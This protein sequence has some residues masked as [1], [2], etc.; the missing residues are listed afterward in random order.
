MGNDVVFT[1]S[2]SAWA[3][4]QRRGMCFTPDRLAQTLLAH[5]RVEH[6]LVCDPFRSIPVR[7]LKRILGRTTG[8][9]PASERAHHYSPGSLR[10]RDPAQIRAAERRY[11]G[12]GRRL[13][14]AAERAGL[15]EPAVITSHP[16]VAGFAPLE[17]ARSVTFYADDDYTAHPAFARLADVYREAYA[18]AGASRRAV[19]AV[20]RPL[21]ERINPRGPSAVLPNGVDPG[22]WVEIPNPPDWLERL[23]RPRM[24]Y[25][26]ALDERMDTERLLAVARSHPDGSVVLVGYV[27]DAARLEPLRRAPNVHIHPH[28]RRPGLPGVLGAADVCLIPHRRTPLTEAMSPLKLYEYLAAGRPVAATDLPPVHDVDERVIIVR[29][30]EDYSAGVDAALRKGPATEDER[31]RFVEANSWRRRHERLLEVALG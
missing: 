24:L 29:D 22:E 26:G 9:F 4:A 5:P 31:R 14:R 28:V 8:S 1:F 6:L 27:P 7:V 18:R 19:F 11:R 10:R 13:Q 21:L 17:W 3:D 20:S 25:L 2:T 23:P 30:G 12:Y 15:R 16:L